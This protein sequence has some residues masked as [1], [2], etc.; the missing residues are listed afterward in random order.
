M[1]WNIKYRVLDRVLSISRCGWSG[2]LNIEFWT[3]SCPSVTVDGVEPETQLLDM[4]PDLLFSC[5]IIV[6]SDTLN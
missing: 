2:A 3:E 1:E 4:L 5:D 6:L